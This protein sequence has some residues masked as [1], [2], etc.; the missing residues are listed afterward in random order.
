LVAR[1]PAYGVFML[2]LIGVFF[3]IVIGLGLL[4][5]FGLLDAI[6]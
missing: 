1:T 2:R 5:I 3:L 4:L 6:F